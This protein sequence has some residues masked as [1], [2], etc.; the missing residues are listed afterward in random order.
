MAAPP[1]AFDKPDF[2]DAID[3]NL[4]SIRDNFTWLMIAAAGQGYILPG[5]AAVAV[6]TTSP[7]VPSEPNTITMTHT[8]GRKMRWTLTW[9]SG[10]VTLIVWEYDRDLGGGFETLVGGTV[11]IT[12]DGADNFTG[13]TF[14]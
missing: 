5:W 12:Y 13:T 14:V 10:K 1:E 4:D 11:T 6:S 9:A 7:L 8:D 3:D 2:A